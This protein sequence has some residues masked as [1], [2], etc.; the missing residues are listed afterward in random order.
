MW[1]ARWPQRARLGPLYCALR[2]ADALTA[3][4]RHNRRAQDDWRPGLSIVIPDRDAPDMLAA[5]LASVDAALERIDEPNQV[6]VVANGAPESAYADIRAAFAHVE[7]VHDDLPLGFGAAIARGLAQAR[8]DWV[9]LLNNDMTLDRAAL[10]EVAAQRSGDVFSISSQIFQRSADGRREETGFTDW[11][12][13]RA[14]VHV[15]H[16]SVDG[17]TPT[18]AH[19]AGS[20]G[21]TLF[22]KAP[23]VRYVRESRCY[24]P[25]YWED[26]EWGVR[27]WR[28][29]YLVLMQPASHAFHRHRATTARFYSIEEINRTIA[30][31]RVLFDARNRA[32]PF[33]VEW[34]MNRICDLDYRTQREM[35]AAT[36]ALETFR[37]RRRTVA[38]APS[39]PCLADPKDVAVQL[40]PVSFSYRLRAFESTSPATRSR[41]LLVTP[42]AVYPP[43]HGGARRIAGLLSR[44]RGDYDIILVSDEAALYE[45]RSFAGFDGLCAVHLVWRVEDAREDTAATLERRMESHGHQALTDTVRSAL[46]RYRPALVQIEYGELAGLVRLRRPGERWILDLHDAIGHGDF[47]SAEIARRFEQE[48]L[49]AYDA[50]TV[51]SQEDRTIVAHPNT[52]CVPNASSIELGDYRPSAST[53]LLFMGPFRYGPNLEGVR[54]FLQD[55]FPKIRAAV[56]DARI[57]VLGGDG[58]PERVRN[59]PAFAQAGVELF[60]H[61][62]DVAAFLDAS[63]LTINPQADIRGS[64]IKVIESLMAGR[65]CV[66]T[67]DGARGFRDSGLKGLVVA[68]DIASMADPIIG[69]LR[70]TASRHRAEAPDASRLA[71][72]QWAHS[73]GLLR[74]LYDSLLASRS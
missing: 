14:G 22:R 62:E 46:V 67:L 59:D 37:R 38:S 2:A 11:Y 51:C 50:I 41:L 9:Y 49:S 19:L 55:A 71:R 65:A 3:A 63:A 18:R 48:V 15:F 68:D 72:Y 53:Q 61:R 26:I 30:R 35:A 34:L 28:D 70:D 73:A 58:A 69:L 32:T 44:L 20:G 24:D 4:S 6:I 1:G 5:A 43:R 56:A 29:G 27:A 39:P 36:V 16:A 74:S 42:F 64:A 52:V 66:S 7:F 60:G 23:L 8:H 54:R 21:A 25:F 31:N 45:G 47:T 33:G 57:A 10:S 13:D 17:S 12:A 40:A